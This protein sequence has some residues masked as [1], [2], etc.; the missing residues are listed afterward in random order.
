[1]SKLYCAYDSEP[2]KAIATNKC[3]ICEKLLCRI[4]GYSENELDYCNACWVSKMRKEANEK[5]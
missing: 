2:N 1:M 5:K 4:C 3:D